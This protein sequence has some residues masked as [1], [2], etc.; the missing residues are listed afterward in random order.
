MSPFELAIATYLA[1]VARECSQ[2][3]GLWRAK[4]AFCELQA[5][6]EVKGRELRLRSGVLGELRD[7]ARTGFAGSIGQGL[8]LWH[9]LTTF[10]QTMVVDFAAACG[11]LTPPVTA[12][13]LSEKRPDF[14][15]TANSWSTFSIFESKGHAALTSRVG[16]KA[17][18]RTALTEQV[19]AGYTRL[20]NAGHGPSVERRIALASAILES[21]PSMSAFSDPENS[22][23]G[24]RSDSA[25]ARLARL[26]Y[27]SWAFVGGSAWLAETLRES[28]GPTQ[29]QLND[30]GE[31]VTVANRVMVA[32]SS[33]SKVSPLMDVL[34][35]LLDSRD[36]AP[37]IIHVIDEQI[38]KAVLAND[39]A[40]LDASLPSRQEIQKLRLSHSRSGGVFLPDG[41]AYVPDFMASRV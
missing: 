21:E 14:L 7:S 25:R 1:S 35:P 13:T 10:Q 39:V 17:D 37:N 3:V 5:N 20:A 34:P 18:L 38:L 15:S 33:R 8:T 29:L 23:I 12:P 28:P 32:I 22:A 30:I 6:C 40:A 9:A 11:R 26:H 16:W 19:D 2:D 4:A 41:T 24:M 31:T 36:A 27:S